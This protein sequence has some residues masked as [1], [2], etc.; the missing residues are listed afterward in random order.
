MPTDKVIWYRRL[1]HRNSKFQTHVIYR[2]DI[3]ISE[4]ETGFK[5][6][7][8]ASSV[9]DLENSGLRADLTFDTTEAWRAS[10]SID[11]NR[12]EWLV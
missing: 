11:P 9:I 12:F 7:L 3:C 1:M 4:D 10:P 2:R 5:L 8:L 6:L